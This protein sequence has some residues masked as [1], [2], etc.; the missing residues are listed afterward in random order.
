MEAV[1]SERTVGV[2][3]P[4]AETAGILPLPVVAAVAH[5]RGLPVIVDAAEML[6]PATNLRRFFAEG[7]DL[8]AFSGGK[9]IGAPAASGM[10]AGRRDLILSA[11]AQ[12]QDMYVRPASWPGPQGG[13]TVEALPDPPQ[14]PVGRIVKVGREEIVGFVVALRRY[15]AKDHRLDTARWR[16][17]A[18]RIA[19]GIDGVHGAR[20][21]I[22][23]D[24]DVSI[25]ALTP[26]GPSAADAA[27]RLIT[28]LR[29]RDPRIWAGEDLIDEGQVAFNVQHLRDDEVDVVIERVR[30]AL[31]AE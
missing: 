30:Q 11:T 21:E 24:H 5:A 28:R 18:E 1:I 12:Q 19:T 9:A 6:P 27:A 7:A 15:L 16:A 13:D 17:M 20:A 23:T 10:L 3:Y 14:Q 4:G 31:A 8:V 29:E 25:V 26:R 2:F 22:L